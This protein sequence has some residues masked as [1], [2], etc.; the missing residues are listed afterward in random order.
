M[1]AF[2][3]IIII[4]II[5]I[6]INLTNAMVSSLSIIGVTTAHLASEFYPHVYF[7]FLFYLFHL[8]G[9]GRLRIPSREHFLRPKLSIKNELCT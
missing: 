4:I 9:I 1:Y 2:L 3:V 8:S 5:I 6:I 7:G